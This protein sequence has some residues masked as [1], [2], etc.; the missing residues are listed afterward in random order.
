MCTVLFHIVKTVL[1]NQHVDNVT[2]KPS[3]ME[4]DVI[5]AADLCSY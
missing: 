2:F 3:C 1:L 4:L 5:L